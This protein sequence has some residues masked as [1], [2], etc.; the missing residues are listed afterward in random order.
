MILKPPAAV[1]GGKGKGKEK[2]GKRKYWRRGRDGAVKWALD[3]E[4]VEEEWERK[5]KGYEWG[6][7]RK[8]QGGGWEEWKKKG[9]GKGESDKMRGMVKVRKPLGKKP[10]PKP[11]PTTVAKQAEEQKRDEEKKK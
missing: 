10:L 3:E 7:G 5:K 1:G 6:G 9:T 4:A 2:E 11:R 8:G